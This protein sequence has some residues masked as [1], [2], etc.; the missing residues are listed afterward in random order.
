VEYDHA[1]RQT[2]L[3]GLR[4]NAQPRT[5]THISDVLYCLRKTLAR[6]YNPGQFQNTDKTQMLFVRG[7][8]IGLLFEDAALHLAV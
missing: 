7:R 6:E 5:G 2:L 8:S 3:D 1:M 4:D